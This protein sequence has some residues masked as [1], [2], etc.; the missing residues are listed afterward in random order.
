MKKQP[1]PTSPS[2]A[3]CVR[4]MLAAD[5]YLVIT[6]RPDALQLDHVDPPAGHATAIVLS[7]NQEDQLYGALKVRQERRRRARERR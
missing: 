5:T 6:E 7:E 2:P 4:I 3:D 1:I